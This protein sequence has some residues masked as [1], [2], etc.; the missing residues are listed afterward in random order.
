MSE[1]T[2][3]AVGRGTAADTVAVTV[4]VSVAVFVTNWTSVV[5]LIVTSVSVAVVVSVKL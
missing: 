2:L 5:G 1:Q 4:W 3:M